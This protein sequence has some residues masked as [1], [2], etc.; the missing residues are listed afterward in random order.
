MSAAFKLEPSAKASEYTCYQCEARVPVLSR[1]S[2][3]M[4][5]ME[6]NARKNEVLLDSMAE[7]L[8]WAGFAPYGTVGQWIALDK[9][10]EVTF[11]TPELVV[12]ILL[13]DSVAD[14]ELPTWD[15]GHSSHIINAVPIKMVNTLLD[16]V[17]F[18]D[19]DGDF[20]IYLR[21]SQS[22]VEVK[23]ECL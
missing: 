8:N 13:H 5:C 3:C 19:D 2:R 7:K 11:H 17:S 10:A 21:K 9:F 16:T 23:L 20:D 1:T 22:G 6:E 18:L 12:D 14:L 15:G 4:K